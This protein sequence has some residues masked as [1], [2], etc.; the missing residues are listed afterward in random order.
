MNPDAM[1]KQLLLT[2][3]F[4]L[5]A[6]GANAQYDT[7]W[8][9]TP[10]GPS[11]SLANTPFPT[12][13][14]RAARTQYIVRSLDLAQVLLPNT[15]VLGICFQVVDDDLTDPACL[16][17]I[18]TQMKN[19]AST[20]L[21]DF[22]SSGLVSTSTDQ[23]INLSEGVLG[24]VFDHPWQWLG[25]GNNSIVEINYERSE[26]VGNSPR[27]LLDQ[28][29]DHTATF[30]GRTG[31]N[32]LG[33]DISSIYPPDVETGSDNSLPAMGLLVDA[34]TTSLPDASSA[35]DLRLSPNPCQVSINA[36]VPSGTRSIRITDMCGRTVLQ[37]PLTSTVGKIDVGSL[38]TGC[39]TVQALAGDGSMA[40]GRFIKE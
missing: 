22:I 35:A 24:I 31:Q 39:Y 40:S 29:L 12:E 28:D 14:A 36:R 5:C 16:L 17:D 6:Y 25:V 8:I 30:T 7:L 1:T 37:R 4:L 19:E 33:Q 34:F 38:P 20:N 9:G 18:H 13:V 32:I 10:D 26:E 23:Q 3:G 15:N 2:T 11:T 21:V 27:I